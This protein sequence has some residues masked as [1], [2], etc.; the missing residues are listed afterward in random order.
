[1]LIDAICDNWMQGKRSKLDSMQAGKDERQGQSEKARLVSFL[2]VEAPPSV[3][4][5]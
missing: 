2:I 4:C 1:M 5:R 3:E